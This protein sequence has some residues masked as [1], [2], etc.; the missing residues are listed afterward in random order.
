MKKQLFIPILL[1]LFCATPTI[2]QDTCAILNDMISEIKRI[3]NKKQVGVEANITITPN[4]GFLYFV[5]MFPIDNTYL[6]FLTN[7]SAF[8]LH[9][10]R[11]KMDCVNPDFR[12][13]DEY[14]KAFHTKSDSIRKSI[15]PIMLKEAQERFKGNPFAEFLAA[16]AFD[17]IEHEQE[18]GSYSHEIIIPK[19]LN[20][21]KREHKAL[22]SE[23]DKYFQQYGKFVADS[24][25][26]VIFFF[27][28]SFFDSLYCTSRNLP[29][30]LEIPQ[31]RVIDANTIL[32]GA[33]TAPTPEHRYYDFINRYLS[34]YKKH[35]EGWNI[36]EIYIQN[37]KE[38][39]SKREFEYEKDGSITEQI[40][41]Y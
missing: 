34:I 32:I 9:K 5:K 26:E 27:K 21:S 6:E 40:T 20:Q 4:E 31:F 10:R 36:S 25:G 19:L 1:L 18:N 15:Y 17:I 24:L 14:S 37:N 30:Y 22:Q 16:N 8:A 41:E 2:A 35:N 13:S 38:K 12:N 7:D 39:I 3:E 29:L 33:F 23:Y 28:Q 11:R